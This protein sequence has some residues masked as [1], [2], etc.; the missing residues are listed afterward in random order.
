MTHSRHIVSALISAAPSCYRLFNHL[1]LLCVWVFCL[2][3]YLAPEEAQCLR[4]PEKSFAPV[5]L[6][7]LSIPNGEYLKHHIYYLTFLD[8]E[9]EIVLAGLNFFSGLWERI[10]LLV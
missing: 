6:S 10:Y 4:K 8:P 5:A 1:I 9:I 7:H 2:H 3:V